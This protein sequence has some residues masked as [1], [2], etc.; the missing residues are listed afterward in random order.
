MTPVYKFRVGEV[1]G[2]SNYLT[3]RFRVVGMRIRETTYEL[4]EIELFGDWSEMGHP[5][6]RSWVMAANVH[7]LAAA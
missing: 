5:E 3:E 2:Y 7:K 1:V 6:M 4:Y